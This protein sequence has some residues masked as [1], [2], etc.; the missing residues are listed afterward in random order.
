MQPRTLRARGSLGAHAGS[1][2]PELGSEDR[3]PADTFRAQGRWG[4]RRRL[5]VLGPPKGPL[6]SGQVGH[7]A[8]A[9]TGKGRPRRRGAGS[10]SAAWL[11]TRGVETHRPAFQTLGLRPGSLST[12][13][14]S[15]CSPARRA[16]TSCARPRSHRPRLGR[17]LPPCW[18]PAQDVPPSLR[19]AASQAPTS[20]GV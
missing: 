12:S 10:G 18:G 14:L 15:P 7:S 6:S 1:P 9:E 8:L 20:P 11:P 5:W 17:R 2:A 16:H 4:G 13:A 19:S 3:R